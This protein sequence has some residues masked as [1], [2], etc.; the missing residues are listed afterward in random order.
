MW[1][2]LNQ[3]GKIKVLGVCQHNIE[4]NTDVETRVTPRE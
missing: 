2:G 3:L 1:R 4:S